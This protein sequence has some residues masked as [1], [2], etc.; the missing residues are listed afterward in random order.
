MQ[1]RPVF[2]V[3]RAL[4]QH[5]RLGMKVNHCAAPAQAAAVFLPRYR[6]AAGSQHDA[7]QGGHLVD[8]GGFAQSEPLFAFHFENGGYRYAGAFANDLIAVVKRPLQLLGQLP[9]QGGFARPHQADEK[10]IMGFGMH[11]FA[12]S[13]ETPPFGAEAS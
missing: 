7:R 11:R 9:S 5:F 2:I 12:F 13:V 8:N 3:A 4:Q 1:Q 10:D 6:A